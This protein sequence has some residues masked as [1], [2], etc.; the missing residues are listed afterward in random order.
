[1]PNPARA[2][3]LTAVAIGLMAQTAAAQ[4]VITQNT[5]IREQLCVGPACLDT[6]SYDSFSATLRLRSFA[7][8]IDFIDTDNS[9]PDTDWQLKAND[10]NGPLNRFMLRDLTAGTT[11]VS[12]VGA[13][14]DNSLYVA[15][16]GKIGLGTS[17]P[18]APLHL[19]TTDNIGIRI[20]R[21]N[22]IGGPQAWET[23]VASTG[24]YVIRDINGGK[25]P[26]VIA[27]GTPDSSLLFVEDEAVFNNLSRN[28]DFVVRSQ[29]FD[30]PL[31]FGDASASNVGIGTNTPQAPLEVS[32][33]ETFSFFRVTATEAA[34]NQSADVVFTEGP[35]GTG[36]FRY[37][38]V[39]GDG[40]EM[41][42]NANGDVTIAGQLF[43]AGSCAAGCDRVF[44]ADYPLPTILEQAAMMRA[45][46][47]LPNV[48]PTPED[49]PFNI[50]AM[51]GGMLNELEKAHL[52]IA[53]LEERDRARAAEN[54]AQEARL[55]RLET[56]VEE[57]AGRP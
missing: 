42:L 7:N 16:D 8:R 48:G 45:H 11:P 36:E 3:T 21:F 37:N 39:D 55:A 52:Y 6:E 28:F 35:L 13:A 17:L 19:D 43:T 20:N 15:A 23:Y 47:H 9:L 56:L 57:L 33:A 4:N 30:A 26:V 41:R 44:D 53:Q 46:K 27:A 25:S 40:P 12:V 38:I 2:L 22:A 32:S 14:P 18:Q 29:T 5:T 1:M 24:S 10:D 51:T 50:T 31:I 49:G 34:T 54:A